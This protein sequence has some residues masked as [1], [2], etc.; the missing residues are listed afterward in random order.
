[1]S[2]FVTKG[3]KETQ[4]T[5]D[6]DIS[7]ARALPSDSSVNDDVLRSEIQKYLNLKSSRAHKEVRAW[8][9][10]N[11]ARMSF[12]SFGFEDFEVTGLHFVDNK[13]PEVLTSDI[14]F[15][16]IENKDLAERLQH[17]ENS[18][19]GISRS[20][21]LELEVRDELQIKNDQM[22]E[23]IKRMHQQIEVHARR[24]NPKESKNEACLI[25]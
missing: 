14:N 6:F 9:A 13:L 11:T 3:C 25:Y 1:M 10:Q 4:L 19:E 8:S 16:I 17:L 5:E 15:S 7:P 21:L 24:V 20:L 18:I 22:R 23:Q 2:E 12:E